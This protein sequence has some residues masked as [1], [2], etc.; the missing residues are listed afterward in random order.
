MVQAQ[1]REVD[2]AVRAQGPGRWSGLDLCGEDA[3]HGESRPLGQGGL[4]WR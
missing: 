1:G 4:G 3:D 2:P